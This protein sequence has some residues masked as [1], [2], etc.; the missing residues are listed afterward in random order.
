M[1]FID[2][3]QGS[4]SYFQ[5]LYNYFGSYFQLPTWID[6]IDGGI[7]SS[8]IIQHELSLFSIFFIILG[9]LLKLNPYWAFILLILFF[10][11]LFLYGLYLNIKNIHNSN[12]IFIIVAFIHLVSFDLLFHLHSL[13][14]LSYLPFSYYYIHK[15]FSSFKLTKLKQLLLIN[16]LF[17]F[18]HV[19]YYNIITLI[20]LPLIIFIIFCFFKI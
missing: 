4:Y 6:F 14:S 15:Y 16:L 20:Y 8:F 10:N 13:I 11:L 17:F 9:N 7:P 5:Y 1:R 19:H 12:E 2:D 18:F 3:T